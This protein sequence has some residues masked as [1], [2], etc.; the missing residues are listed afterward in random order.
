MRNGQNGKPN[1]YQKVE[2]MLGNYKFIC[3]GIQSNKETLQEMENSLT[4]IGAVDYSKEKI[5]TT[6]ETY[7]VEQKIL[8]AERSEPE[9]RRLYANIRR[10]QRKIDQLDRAITELPEQERRIIGY[11]YLD[12][13]PWDQIA[14]HMACDVRTCQRKRK[15]AIKKIVIAVFGEP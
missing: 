13:L 6:N 11:R 3:L 7:Q 12:Q 2:G 8:E 10:N 1:N 15:K 4:D 14:E 5:D 9:K